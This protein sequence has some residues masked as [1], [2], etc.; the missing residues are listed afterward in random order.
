MTDRDFDSEF[1]DMLARQFAADDPELVDYFRDKLYG[2]SAQNDPDH[3]RFVN[4]L[5]RYQYPMS[6]RQLR[7]AQSIVIARLI[8]GLNRGEDIFHGQD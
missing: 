3:D 2:D 7:A 5:I 4:G 6:H 8:P 1:G